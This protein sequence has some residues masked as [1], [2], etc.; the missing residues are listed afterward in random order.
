MNRFRQ[1]NGGFTLIELLV[2]IAIIAILI[3]LLL[4]AVQKVREAANQD[5]AEQTLRQVMSTAQL[6]KTL[7][8]GQFPPSLPL[9]VEFCVQVPT[10]T[11]K[12]D[13]RLATSQLHGYNFLLIPDGERGE[14]EPYPGVTGAETLSFP[15]GGEIT[16]FPTPGADAGRQRML[17]AV[18]GDGSVR[19]ARFIAMSPTY[20]EEIRNGA[21]PLTGGE[22]STLIDKDGSLTLSGAEVFALDPDPQTRFVAQFLAAAK[23]EMKIGIA[24]ETAP[25]EW[26]QPYVPQ[27]NLFE[28]AFS[29]NFL[30]G[31]TA[32]FV[33]D[34]RAERIALFALKIAAR[35]QERGN[36]RLEAAAAG[37]YL[38]WISREVHVSLTR[39]NFLVLGAWLSSITEL[40]APPE[41]PPPPSPTSSAVSGRR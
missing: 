18:M 16:S 1:R 9:L 22:L 10:C 34:P 32:A 31:L 41:P 3:G 20:P 12:L 15:L 6:F 39:T 38:K 36:E 33:E 40:P 7:N 24:N 21:S 5:A 37:F 28:P 13:P 19:L 29:Y 27:G 23:T 2:V 17:Q 14:A 8:Q 4:P 26:L 11:P 35:A 25:S 30:S